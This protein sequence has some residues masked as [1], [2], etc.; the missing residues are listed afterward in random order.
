MLDRGSGG[1]EVPVPMGSHGSAPVSY[2]ELSLPV[3]LPL[4]CA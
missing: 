2:L 4:L 1:E 3:L